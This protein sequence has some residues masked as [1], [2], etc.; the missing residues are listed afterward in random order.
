MVHLFLPNCYFHHFLVSVC[1]INTDEPLP[2]VARF[3]TE[4]EEYGQ[5]LQQA[6]DIAAYLQEELIHAAA[7]EREL[8]TQLD[9]LQT[10]LKQRPNLLKEFEQDQEMKQRDSRFQ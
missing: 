2:K 1:V 8:Q 3:K 7:R 5:Q 9:E 4:Q 6:A 10:W